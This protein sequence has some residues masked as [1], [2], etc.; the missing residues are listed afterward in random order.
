M[1]TFN[2]KYRAR[3]IYSMMKVSAYKTDLYLCVCGGGGAGHVFVTVGLN[4]SGKPHQK[5]LP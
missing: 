2:Q 4:F 3:D 5:F 1:N